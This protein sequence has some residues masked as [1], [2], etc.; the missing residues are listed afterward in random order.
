M[1]NNQPPPV[2]PPSSAQTTPNHTG[3][4]TKKTRTLSGIPP[5][6]SVSP[7]V[8][9]RLPHPEAAIWTPVQSAQR[10]TSNGGRTLPPKNAVTPGSMVALSTTNTDSFSPTTLPLEP[11]GDA[12]LNPK[13]LN[14]IDGSES[15]MGVQLFPS[16]ELAVS[17]PKPGNSARAGD[18]KTYRSLFQERLQKYGWGAWFHW[19]ERGP[20]H[21]RE[22]I[23]I[24]RIGN[25]WMYGSQ[26]WCSNK[27]SAKEDAARLAL[28]WFDQYGYK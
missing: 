15:R 28:V 11:Y 2:E 9:I 22:Y 24:F 13:Q 6:S 4:G 3:G 20:G 16:D 17:G 7:G 14:G 5:A 10:S 23:G 1:N 26:N 19:D 27:D 25:Y 12:R 21:A 8:S 18:S